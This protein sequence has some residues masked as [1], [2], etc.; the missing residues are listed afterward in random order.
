MSFLKKAVNKLKDKN[1]G[2]EK[3]SESDS[4]LGST[5]PGQAAN[6]SGI[7][8]HGSV[9]GTP[10][11]SR[12]SIDERRRSQEVVREEKFRRSMEKEQKKAEAKKRHTLA[13]IESENFMRE[14]PP[15]LT[16]LYRPYSMNMSK[17]WNHEH[18]VL[19][20]EIDFPSKSA[21]SWHFG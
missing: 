14:G 7:A 5:A 13:R 6:G 20:K 11:D 18:R 2:S 8:R 10:N 9:K 17:N 21:L 12:L 3:Q 1:S 4:T 16:K 19:F 15:D